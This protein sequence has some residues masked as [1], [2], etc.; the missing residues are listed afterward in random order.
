MRVGL[1]V[2]YSPP[3]ARFSSVRALC[4]DEPICRLA[5]P[6]SS[7]LPPPAQL[8]SP[9]PPRQSFPPAIPTAAP[10]H[11]PLLSQT[12]PTL[13]LM[14]TD[15]FSFTPGPVSFSSL[16][17]NLIAAR[18]SG[19]RPRETIKVTTQDSPFFLRKL[20]DKSVNAK[21]PRLP[22]SAPT[23]SDAIYL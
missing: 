19:G 17:L 4:I 9:L 14:H 23:T 8:R 1:I 18:S 12:S 20:A 13:C 7:R 10:V 16:R 21:Y 6:L 11:A 5:L 15:V 22:S 3:A 2:F